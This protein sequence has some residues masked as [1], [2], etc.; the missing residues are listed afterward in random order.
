MFLCFSVPLCAGSLTPRHQLLRISAEPPTGRE[1]V[2][3]PRAA[4]CLFPSETIFSS[5]KG[6]WSSAEGGFL[7]G[8]ESQ[9]ASPGWWELMVRTAGQDRRSPPAFTSGCSYR[10][11][12]Q[13]DPKAQ[14][15]KIFRNGGFEK[16]DIPALRLKIL[17]F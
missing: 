15:K 16:T 8:G 5:T 12:V 9:D 11:G 10:S 7:H 6:S 17:L 1:R 3:C 14:T 2:S 4:P 13:V